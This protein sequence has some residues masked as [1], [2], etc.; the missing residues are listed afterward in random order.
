[1]TYSGTFI[2]ANSGVALGMVT[3]IH[4]TVGCLL[5]ALVEGVILAKG[6]RVR[7]GRVFWILFLA[8]FVSAWAGRALVGSL[9]WA[10]YECC[11]SEPL[12]RAAWPIF[13]MVFAAAFGFT[14]ILELPFIRWA[15]AKAGF[16]WRRALLWSLALHVVTYPALAL[17]YSRVSSLSLHNDYTADDTL[18]FVSVDE[19][20]WVWFA[21]SSM[22]PSAECGQTAKSSLSSSSSSSG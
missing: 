13:W 2:I 9:G 6:A 5:L 7:F 17:W 19:D 14:V 1:M 16:K 3:S 21:R 11:F 4:L 10:I 22:A 12:I 18:S 8:N 20:V 15:G